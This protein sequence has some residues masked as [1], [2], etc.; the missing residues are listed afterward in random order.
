MGMPWL[1]FKFHDK[2]QK[3]SRTVEQAKG[4]D[5]MLSESKEGVTKIIEL[6]V[7][8]EVLVDRICGKKIQKKSKMQIPS[9]N[10][11][12]ESCLRAVSNQT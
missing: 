11:F 2:N 5:A 4:L 1:E 8:D 12:Y 9:V 7:P 6:S 10:P 3:T